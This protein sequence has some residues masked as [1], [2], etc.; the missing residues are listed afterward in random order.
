DHVAAVAGRDLEVERERARRVA[1][2]V[3]DGD[4]ARQVA[5]REV[6]RDL[7]LLE[8]RRTEAR[9]AAER[10]HDVG[11]VDAHR[12]PVP[13]ELAHL[14]HATEL[15]EGLPGRVHLERAHGGEETTAARRARRA[16]GTRHA[17]P[18][19]ERGAVADALRE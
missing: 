3:R 1:E 11:A 13:C 19:E 7:S 6:R 12:M 18:D 16:G 10:Q 4:A 15:A 9:R 8:R 17:I 5:A 2:V 14:P